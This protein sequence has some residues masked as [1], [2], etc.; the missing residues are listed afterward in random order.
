[1]PNRLTRLKIREVSSVDRGAGKG[2]KVLL[3]KRKTASGTAVYTSVDKRDLPD[4]VIAYLK[5]TFT[6]DQ[7]KD[8]A[9]K[10]Q[11]MP[12]GGFPIATTEDL[13]NAIRAVGRAKDPDAAKAH[14]KARAKDLGESDAIP[15]SWSKRAPAI[16]GSWSQAAS[17]I[18]KAALDAGV[19]TDIAAAAQAALAASI[20]AIVHGDGTPTAKRALVSKSFHQC[21]EFL[22]G[23]LI[24]DDAGTFTTAC[25]DALNI[26]KGEHPM[27]EPTLAELNKQLASTTGLLAKALGEIQVLKMSDKHKDFHSK[28]D[29]ETDADKAKKSKFAEMSP[30]DRDDYMA[31][32][33]IEKRSPPLT[34]D[35]PVIKTLITRADQASAEAI[36]LKKKLAARDEADAIAD[37]KKRAVALG[38]P[39]THGEVMR[40]AYGGDTAS[41]AA[42][43]ALLIRLNKA[44]TNRE[45]LA[46]ILKEFGN[47]GG[48]TGASAYEKLKAKAEEYRKTD[49][50]KNMTPQQAFT[51]VFTD[52]VNKALADEHKSDEIKKRRAA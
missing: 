41:M 19:D 21:V 25:A 49:A 29:D 9:D 4:D 52:P 33:P 17:A 15:D 35:D 10:G 40:K 2:V 28:M 18:D 14:I 30:D 50:G 48:T 34:S 26:V 27:A 46:E 6:A 16:E 20:D 44:L 12:D 47:D 37:F 11:A 5:R 1:M 32:H 42:H 45:G 43:E 24:G 22:A 8:M 23:E 39:E 38:L 13:H 31:K 36:E 3:M 7:R 51:K